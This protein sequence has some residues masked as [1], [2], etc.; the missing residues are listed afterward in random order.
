MKEAIALGFIIGVALTASVGVY[1]TET[2]E[3][4]THAKLVQTLLECGCEQ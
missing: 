4:Q 2:N 1:V 3:A